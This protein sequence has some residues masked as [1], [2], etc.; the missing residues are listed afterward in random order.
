MMNCPTCKTE[1]EV[2][3]F[4]CAQC[5]LNLQGH[6]RLPR[7]ARLSQEHMKLAEAFLLSGGNLKNLA[8]QMKISYPTLRHRMDALFAELQSIVDKDRKAAE[9]ILAKIDLGTI[10]P[11][12]GLRLIRE[13]NG[14]I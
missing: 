3:Q 14:E 10:N 11:Q 8:E 9:E 4:H 6:F 12:E 13:M 1:M 7:L 2:S 5:N